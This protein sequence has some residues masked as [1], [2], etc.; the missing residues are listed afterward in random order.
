MLRLAHI[1]KRYKENKTLLQ[2]FV[3]HRL[4]VTLQVYDE[5]NNVGGL[6]TKKI[7]KLDL[8][9]WRVLNVSLC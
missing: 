4:L 6:Y 2:L 7:V 5:W 1:F 8:T 3:L 9:K